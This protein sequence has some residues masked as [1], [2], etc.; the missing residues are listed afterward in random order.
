MKLVMRVPIP[1][2]TRTCA[3]L[4]SFS[5]GMVLAATTALAAADAPLPKDLP[6]FGRDKPLPIARIDPST[7][8]NGLQ[9]WLV[10]RPG[11]PR[12][13]A[14][15]TVRGGTA[16]DPTEMLGISR[17][18]GDLLTAGTSTR[19]SR[20]IAEELQTVGAEMN[21]GTGDDAFTLSVAGLSSGA[22]KMLEVLADI[23]R[24]SSFPDD[25]VELARGNAIQGLKVSESRPGTL[26]E[27]IFADAEFGNHPYALVLPKGSVLESITPESAPPGVPQPLPPGPLS[28]HRG[29]SDGRECA[30]GRDREAVRKLEGRGTAR[31]P[32]RRR[33]RWEGSAG[34]WC[35]IGRVR[36]S[37]R[38]A[39]GGRS[40]PRRIPTTTRC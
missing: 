30:E 9:V 19:S 29:R 5:A 8:A 4:L 6:S 23:A 33:R 20:Q 24:N 37:P 21:V 40:S 32:A 38:S 10:P 2:F 25:E 39:S 7:L 26:V 17:V 11:L 3:F 36:F 16:A 28:S 34:S 31:G 15:L 1:D 14:V 27:R 35:S 12:L 18:L 22:G 13:V